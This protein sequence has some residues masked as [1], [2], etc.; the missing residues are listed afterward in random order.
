[1]SLFLRDDLY[2]DP[3]QW[4]HLNEDDHHA[5][6]VRSGPN[7]VGID[8]SYTKP[9]V[10]E[11]KRVGYEFVVGYTSLNSN[12]ALPKSMVDS[13]VAAG[14]RVV[15]VEQESSTDALAGYNLGVLR[16]KQAFDQARVVGYPGWAP[17][18][19]AVDFSPSPDQLKVVADYFRGI[20]AVATEQGRQFGEYGASYVVDYLHNAGIT[21]W[22]WQTKAWSG[23]RVSPHAHFLQYAGYAGLRP[24]M[25]TSAVD[26]NLLLQ[27]WPKMGDKPPA[28]PV[29]RYGILN[30][31]VVGAACHYP[32]VV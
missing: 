15:L 9:P 27:D 11:I 4:G 2:K 32:R 14:I 19:F 29:I 22:H 30:A 17:H 7:R 5:L 31:P 3:R 21:K 23:G 28:P 10:S 18:F 24:P 26:E 12:K 25:S 8:F 6:V 13:C 20:S 16:A 1:M